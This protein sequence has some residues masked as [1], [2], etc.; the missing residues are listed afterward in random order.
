M[1]SIVYFLMEMILCIDNRLWN[2]MTM[3]YKYQ[4]PKIVLKLGYR[5]LKVK[6]EDILKI[7]IHTCYGQY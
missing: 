1:Y 3:R 6:K 4:L 5:Q 7:A 2:R